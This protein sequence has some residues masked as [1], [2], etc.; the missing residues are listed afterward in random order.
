MKE[1]N[2]R[3]D[4]IKSITSKKDFQ[5]KELEEKQKMV[6]ALTLFFCCPTREELEKQDKKEVKKF[7]RENN[8]I[9][10]FFKRFLSL[11]SQALCIKHLG[12]W[13]QNYNVR[14]FSFNYN[15]GGIDMFDDINVR[16]CKF[17]GKVHFGG[18]GGYTLNSANI[19]VGAIIDVCK[20]KSI[21]LDG[22]HLAFKTLLER[23]LKNK[24][25]GLSEIVDGY[26]S[27]Y[28]KEREERDRRMKE[29]FKEFEAS[30]KRLQQITSKFV[31]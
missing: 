15:K 24:S 22:I 14:S 23:D 17:C 10:S 3:A 6:E 31:I 8:L 11:K 19:M 4:I 5:D 12:N 1:L 25:V 9:P 30:L 28:T 26:P 16:E 20:K 2:I 18:H 27:P 29:S 7:L 21:N 13:R